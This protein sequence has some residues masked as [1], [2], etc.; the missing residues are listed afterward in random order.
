MAAVGRRGPD[1]AARVLLVVALVALAALALQARQGL[2]WGDLSEP[3]AVRWARVIFGSAILVGLFLL[4]RRLL[5]RL[6]RAGSAR[7]HDSGRSEPEG[8]PFPL[9]LRVLAGLVVLAGL[10]VVWF[11]VRSIAPPPANEGR[12][13]PAP[14]HGV[15]GVGSPLDERT[16][17]GI[18]L[19][20]GAVLLVATY[21]SRWLAA[22]RAVAEPE[23]FGDRRAEA[24]AVLAAVDAA[25]EVLRTETDPR[26]AVLSAYAAMAHHLSRGLGH[27][28]SGV[29]RSDTAT[30]LLDRSVAA[31]L[32]GDAA[33]RTLTD[34]FREARFSRHPMDESARG[35]AERCLHEVRAEL[36]V[37][38]G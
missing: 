10:A 31:G 27:R 14:G 2:D 38:G 3:V 15:G 4:A 29:R 32:V 1:V 22:R 35:R 13:T 36:A 6:R 37:R 16:V 11:I 18:A 28:G 5:R 19:V 23:P 34:L 7:H 33:A 17:I 26:A 12:R 25:E 20:T 21:G 9:L 24:A 30:E 8:E